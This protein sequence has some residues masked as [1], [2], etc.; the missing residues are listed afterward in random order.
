[1]KFKSPSSVPRGANLS[2]AL[3]SGPCSRSSLQIL[4][5]CLCK[6][7][8]CCMW[9]Y[10]GLFFFFLLHC[11]GIKDFVFSRFSYFSMHTHTDFFCNVLRTQVPHHIF[12]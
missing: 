1:M 12:I 10:P 3:S 7:E 2:D 11:I 8:M 9:D 5:D 6:K 4:C